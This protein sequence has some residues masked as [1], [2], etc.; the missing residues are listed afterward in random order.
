MRL[1][2]IGDISA[3]KWTELQ[4]TSVGC[5]GVEWIHLTH[6]SILRFGE[7]GEFLDYMSNN[8]LVMKDLIIGVNAFYLAVLCSYVP[9]HSDCV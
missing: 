4:Y 3:D 8:Q 6:N 7:G 2:S 5:E 9:Q 1:I